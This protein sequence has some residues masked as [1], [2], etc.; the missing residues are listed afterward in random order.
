MDITLLLKV[1]FSLRLLKAGKHV[2]QEKPAA[3]S[4]NEAEIALSHYKS[5]F[6][7]MPNPLIWAVAENYRFE[8]ALVEGKKLVADVGKMMSVQL[9]VEGSMNN[10]NPYF[11]SS[12]RRNFSGGFILDMGVHMI[13]GLRMLVG[14]EVTSVSALTSHVDMTLPPPD[15]IS[16]TFQLENGCSGVFVMSVSTRSPKIFWRIVGL[17]GT[18]QVERGN[19]D[20]RRGFV[21]LKYS[22]DGQCKTSFYQFSGVN[23][24]LKAFI[25]DI[26]EVTLKKASN[27]KA[28][29]RLSFA[30]GARDVAVLDAMLE[31]GSKQGAVVPVKYIAA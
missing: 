16:S 18:V 22:S 5:V 27:H 3:A 11:S 28:E 31:S 26:S 8:P 10:E 25:H 21:V 14:C 24:E 20:G 12:W 19:I 30:E 4:I 6:G 29:A 17:N 1:D 15:N 9:I 7:S 23:E 13:A 2:I